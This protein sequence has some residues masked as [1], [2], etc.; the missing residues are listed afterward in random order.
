MVYYPSVP[1]R[2]YAYIGVRQL[3]V[4]YPAGSFTGSD[5]GE[6]VSLLEGG[7]LPNER[8]RACD[9]DMGVELLSLLM[10]SSVDLMLTI[11]GDSYPLLR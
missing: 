2:Y 6:P 8:L 4:T 5:T 9:L 3:T 10:G 7:I 1:K 11:N